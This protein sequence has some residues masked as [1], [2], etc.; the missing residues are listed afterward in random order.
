[1]N[2]FEGNK[3]EVGMVIL[4]S[5][6]TC[7]IYMLYWMYD[8][9][10]LLAN[11]NEDYDTN[12]GLVVIFTILTCGIYGIYWWYKISM[13]FVTSQQLVQMDYISDNS[14][15]LLILSISQFSIIGV[16]I[17]QSDLNKFWD[18]LN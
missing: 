4:L 3:R 17:L 15:L 13:M 10:R 5:I 11:F 2:R 9:T 6:V 7:G 18:A 8:T 16:A 1:M 12:P 14:T